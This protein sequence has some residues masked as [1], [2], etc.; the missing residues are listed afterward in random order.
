MFSLR[1]LVRELLN[2]LNCLPN[3]L[4]HKLIPS[5]QKWH[6]PDND[7]YKNKELSHKEETLQYIVV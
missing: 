4:I 1:H 6:I 2:L 5:L 3:N 7:Y